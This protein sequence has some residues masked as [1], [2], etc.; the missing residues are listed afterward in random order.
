M[1]LI[2]VGIDG[3]DGVGVYCIVWKV[4]WLTG[5]INYIDLIINVVW[6]NELIKYEINLEE[7]KILISRDSTVVPLLG[8]PHNTF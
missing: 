2:L 5:L 7:Y 8:G 3:G 1:E 4:F 6:I